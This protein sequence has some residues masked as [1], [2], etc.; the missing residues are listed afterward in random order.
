MKRTLAYGAIGLAL[1]VG[2]AQIAPWSGQTPVLVGLGIALALATVLGELLARVH[3]PRILGFALAGMLCGAGG[4]GLL[5]VDSPEGSWL[6]QLLFGVVGFAVGL[7]LT[8]RE[9][10]L[11]TWTRAIG[12]SISQAVVSVLLLGLAAGPLLGLVSNPFATPAESIPLLLLVGL[13]LWV[14]ASDAFLAVAVDSKPRGGTTD[15]TF[16][17]TALG[18]LL[19]LLAFPLLVVA[20]FDA[21]TT[22]TFDGLLW[23]LLIGATSGGLVA[24]STKLSER[25]GVALLVLLAVAAVLT[26]EHDGWVWASLVVAGAFAANLSVQ[27]RQLSKTI[28]RRLRPVVAA[29][30]VL[31][32]AS[33]AL[34]IEHWPLAFLI[35]GLRLAALHVGT[36]LGATFTKSRQELHRVGGLAFVSQGVTPFLLVSSVML[37][38]PTGT[39]EVLLEVV[40]INLLLGPLLLR[41]ALTR[42]EQIERAES[43][44]KAPIVRLE[45]IG[46]PDVRDEQLAAAL[47]RMEAGI[48]DSIVRFRDEVEAPQT[49]LL[50]DTLSRLQTRAMAGLDRIAA[51]IRSGEID[52]VSD[53]IEQLTI[54]FTTSLRKEVEALTEGIEALEANHQLT[55]HLTAIDRV[56]E[57]L[58]TVV[59]DL[60]PERRRPAPNDTWWISLLK[61]GRR[62]RFVLGGALGGG[63]GQKRTVNLTDLALHYI[64]ARAGEVMDIAASGM[65]VQRLD[66]LRKVRL[67]LELLERIT[68]AG[69]TAVSDPERDFDQLIATAGQEL[70]EEFGVIQRELTRN[71]DWLVSRFGRRIGELIGKCGHAA[72]L[73]GTWELPTHRY[74][75]LRSLESRSRQR[76][77]LKLHQSQWKVIA[78]STAAALVLKLEGVLFVRRFSA[79]QREC[80]EGVGAGV[81]SLLEVYPD[82]VV[83]Q[84]EETKARIEK[85]FLDEGAKPEAIGRTLESEH[86]IL[87]G[88]ITRIAIG[89][90]SAGLDPQTVRAPFDDFFEA[91]EHRLADL[92]ESF[93]TH[94]T[95]WE[96]Q[97]PDGVPPAVDP[98]L[99][100]FRELVREVLEDEVRLGLHDRQKA[101]LNFLRDSVSE[102]N[103]VAHF[104]SFSFEG[105]EK[106]LI[107]DDDGEPDLKR[108][109]DLALGGLDETIDRV[110]KL[111]QRS[112]D[113]K[114]KISEAIEQVADEQAALLLNILDAVDIAEARRR[115]GLPEV[116]IQSLDETTDLQA[117]ESPSKLSTLLQTTV[118]TP[119]SR[120]A[121]RIRTAVGLLD[122]P[123]VRLED[124]TAVATFQRFEHVGVPSSYRRLF[125]TAAFGVE[126]ILAGQA[127]ELAQLG[128]AVARW[129]DGHPSAILVVGE[130]GGGRTTLIERAFRRYLAEFP[131]HRKRLVGRVRDEV[132]LARELSTLVFGKKAK[133]LADVENRIRDRGDRA[134]VILEE[135]QHLM[136]RTPSGLRPLEAF[137]DFVSRPD[138][139][140]LWIVT[141]D[142]AAWRFMDTFLG[143]GDAFSQRVEVGRL[144]QKATEQLVM[145]RHQVSGL[146]LKFHLSGPSGEV[147]KLPDHVARD[148]YFEALHHVAEGHPVMTMFYWLSSIVAASE[149]RGISVSWPPREESQWVNRLSS[150]R[151]FQLAS[152]LMHGSVTAAEFAQIARIDPDKASARLGQLRSLNLLEQVPGKSERFT[153]NPLLYKPLIDGLKERNML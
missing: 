131:V 22:T 6:W 46:L 65:A 74:R 79:L 102:M 96:A 54:D 56:C 81:I 95:A 107:G 118:S 62:L 100:P 80:A 43:R 77:A 33:F 37:V 125:E 99:F 69:L 13:I 7:R 122:V 147:A 10:G 35:V 28:E 57:S 21:S 119:A 150:Q 9:K 52:E 14:P 138:S 34:H 4:F 126:D 88:F 41:L 144:D 97:T 136:L 39:G 143:A 17:T 94:A 116:G 5:V 90:L 139:H 120:I 111:T 140:I 25:R 48:Q 55:R 30:F 110:R 44:A 98:Q 113:R 104:L 153:V 58:P 11:R 71:G 82:E 133:S 124:L 117:V 76:V 141:V 112:I 63:V 45:D 146:D 129:R 75:R 145:R 24:I 84:C 1:A 130:R 36:A 86:S 105:A 59:V 121:Q 50:T 20:A 91:I 2:T 42:A 149:D 47:K 66:L 70:T 85:A 64:S 68:L 101:V 49:V 142:S 31:L 73:A 18:E 103:E 51:S 78:R 67:L 93:L 108:A 123:Q 83:D 134:V 38:L 152:V 87:D 12:L 115:A 19:A 29:L 16:S 72:L 3:I 148:R 109:R 23:S 8:H 128:V 127:A 61:R 106:A 137:L 27:S 132:A 26:I 60:E 89:E 40:R 114:Q 135:I 92:P 15:L 32:G 151:L 53:L